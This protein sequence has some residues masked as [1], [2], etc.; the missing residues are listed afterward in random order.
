M[1]NLEK[2][3]ERFLRKPTQLT[4]EDVERVLEAFGYSL[5]SHSGTSHRVFRKPGGKTITVPIDNGHWVKGVYIQKIVSLLNL[6]E[7]YEQRKRA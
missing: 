1:S 3:I 4:F 7:W 5:S 6:E 2:L